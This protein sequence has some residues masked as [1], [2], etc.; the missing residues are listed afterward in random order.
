MDPTEIKKLV[1]ALIEKNIQE[2]PDMSHD[3]LSKI[4]GDA[5]TKALEVSKDD[6]TKES[7]ATEEQKKL[8]DEQV[9][10]SVDDTFAAIEQ[11]RKVAEAVNKALAAVGVKTKP[12]PDE[13]NRELTDVEKAALRSAPLGRG[14]AIIR[15]RVSTG[16]RHGPVPEN[17]FSLIRLCKCLK[18]KNTD[19]ALEELAK[20]LEGVDV[21]K[22]MS[23]ANLEEG[24]ITVPSGT[25]GRLIDVLRAKLVT[26]KV[27]MTVQPMTD[28][29]L[30]IPVLDADAGVFWGAPDNVALIEG[31]GLK[32]SGMSLVLKDLT[33]LIPIPNRLLEDAT[34]EMEARLRDSIVK[35]LRLAVDKARL[36]GTGGN[37]PVGLESYPGCTEITYTTLAL[38]ELE[39]VREFIHKCEL[40]ESEIT[41]F[42]T[43][44]TLMHQLRGE[45]DAVGKP[46]YNENPSEGQRK[47]LYGYPVETTTQCKNTA[48]VTKL[49]MFGGDF[50]EVLV[51][52]KGGIKIDASGEVGFKENVTWIR[53]MMR[54]DI[55]IEH[56]KAIVRQ[57]VDAS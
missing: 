8:I 45:K 51:G 15:S 37:M 49:W 25:A 55:G 21:E 40:V 54:E 22:A 35:K 23:T 38:F 3:E 1:D 46:I 36:V 53:A 17:E 24:G 29:T 13:K 5:V 41:G 18:D 30:T 52:N 34:F 57:Y 4:V 7:L 16:P 9:K 27:G 33:A 56:P 39:C 48:T 6:G 20:D 10:K 11:E 19:G 2:K 31:A 32:F 50:S 43:H 26:D 47:T 14:P 44:P 42:I 12:K 28:A